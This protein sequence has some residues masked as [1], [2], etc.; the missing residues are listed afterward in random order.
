MACG[1]RV[2]VCGMASND[3]ALDESAMLPGT[4]CGS[5][6]ALQSQVKQRDHV[7]VF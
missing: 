3:R 4:E 6:K 7:M 2:S 1:L 5:M